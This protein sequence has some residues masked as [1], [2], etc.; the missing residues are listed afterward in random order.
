VALEYRTERADGAL[1]AAARE[2]AAELAA[3]VKQYDGVEAI[4][5]APLLALAAGDTAA[6]HYLVWSGGSLVGYAQRD[7]GGSAEMAVEPK[8]RRHGI[9]RILAQALFHDA[10]QVRLWAHGDLGPSRAVARELGLA[11][12]REL[13]EMASERSPSPAQPDPAVPGAATPGAAQHGE[14]AAQHGEGGEVAFRPFGAKGDREAWVGLNALAFAGH[15]EQGRLTLEDLDQRMA[16]SWFDPAGL[17]FAHPAPQ[18]APLGYVWTKIE[19]GG[20]EIYAIGVHPAAQGKRLG[21]KLLDLGLRHLEEQ[22]VAE[23]RLFVEADN[24]PAIASYRRQGFALT[25]RDIQ[26]AR[27][28]G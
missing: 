10:P 1:G 4:S 17:I 15:P 5:E 12:V 13:W 20:G 9:G 16:Q 6:A 14:V 19:G 3:R 8:R 27:P 25:R 22:G 11:A 18:A 24:A 26:Y 7:P 21:T 23:V 2:A 28:T